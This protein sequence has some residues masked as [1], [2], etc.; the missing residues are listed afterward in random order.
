MF[1]WHHQLSSHGFGWT[2]GVGDGQGGLACCGP[3]CQSKRLG[4]DP[5]VEK[6]P[7]RR[8]WQPTLVFLPGE[9]HGQR[10]LAG[11][12]LRG[13]K[14]SDT[15][16]QLNNNNKGM[17]SPFCI[18][19]SKVCRQDMTFPRSF[20][21][22]V[23]CLLSLRTQGFQNPLTSRAHVGQ[24]KEQS[25]HRESHYLVKWRVRACLQGQLF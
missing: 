14:E 4:F 15:A 8:E 20:G 7:W 18:E 5:W 24:T 11:S 6:I 3:S 25:S 22:K 16:E 23:L 10:S 13:H 9:S 2:L 1:G 12:S 17:S 21:A 19:K